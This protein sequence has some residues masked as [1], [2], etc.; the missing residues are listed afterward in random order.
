M[1]QKL[2][3][4]GSHRLKPEGGSEIVIVPSSNVIGLFQ[5]YFHEAGHN[6]GENIS[7]AGEN[8]LSHEKVLNTRIRLNPDELSSFLALN[9]LGSTLKIPLK[10]KGTIK[11]VADRILM[12]Y[13]KGKWK[14]ELIDLSHASSRQLRKQM[15]SVNNGNLNTVSV[16]E[17]LSLDFKNNR[18]GRDEEMPSLLMEKECLTILE[19]TLQLSFEYSPITPEYATS[20]H[21]RAKKLL[22]YIHERGWKVP[23]MVDMRNRDK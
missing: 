4:Q 17:D 10:M 9:L 13:T 7:F 16:N 20:S 19:N 18:R 12:A 5:T 21:G 23:S 3:I 1:S 22:D 15:R 2:D 6:I 8:V 14:P 11:R